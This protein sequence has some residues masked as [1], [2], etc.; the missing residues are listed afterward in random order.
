MKRLML[1]ALAALSACDHPPEAVAIDR[2]AAMIQ[3]SLE[4]EADNMEAMAN[5]AVDP[6]A[7]DALENAADRLEDAKH[8]VGHAADAAKKDLPKR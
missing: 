4:Q 1:I 7:A 2:N 6:G 8:D 5:N 3:A